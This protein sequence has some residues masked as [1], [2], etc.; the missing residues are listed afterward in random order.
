VSFVPRE[1]STHQQRYSSQIVQRHLAQN[2]PGVR[3]VEATGRVLQS[4]IAP[5]R[6]R[7]GP[8]MTD[9][10]RESEVDHRLAAVRFAFL[11]GLQAGAA[12]DE[13]RQ[14]DVELVAEN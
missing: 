5:R 9:G 10:A 12:T 3:G 1:V 4:E 7:Q 6:R 2:A 13:A 8:S 14:V 11:A